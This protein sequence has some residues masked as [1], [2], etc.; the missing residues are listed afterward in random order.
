METSFSTAVLKNNL[1]KF[2]VETDDGE[3]LKKLQ[4]YI[5]TLSNS[6]ND[7]WNSLSESEKSLTN[8]GLELLNKGHRVSN[9]EVKRK[10]DQILRKQ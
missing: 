2:I 5:L 4:A 8:K 1:H 9:H 7:W 6:K 10:A 3:V